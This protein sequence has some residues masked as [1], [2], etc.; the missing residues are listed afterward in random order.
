MLRA[1]NFITVPHIIIIIII[2]LQYICSAMKSEDTGRGISNFKTI[3]S[4]HHYSVGV[5][6]WSIEVTSSEYDVERLAAESRAPLQVVW[7]V[8]NGMEPVERR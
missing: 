8:Q 2:G 6:L 3:T 5:M 4:T 7:V 1:G